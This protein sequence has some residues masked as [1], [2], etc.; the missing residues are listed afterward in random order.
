M[1][2]LALD[3]RFAVF[4]GVLQ[5]LL[6]ELAAVVDDREAAKLKELVK[7]LK[8]IGL[9]TRSKTRAVVFSERIAGGCQA[10][11]TGREAGSR[12]HNQH[13]HVGSA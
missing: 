2:T 3:R 1:L 13:G 11:C 9:G 10:E 8:D 6:G 7:Q 4:R 5:L 12:R